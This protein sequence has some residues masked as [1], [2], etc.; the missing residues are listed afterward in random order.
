MT[1]P[2][3]QVGE[4]EDPTLELPQV[5]LNDRV[6]IFG[7]TGTGKSV[8]AHS[9]FR[10]IPDQW[11]RIIIDITDSIHEPSA[12]D[13]YDPTDIPWDKSYS[14]RFIPDIAVSLD[15]QIS[16]LFMGM[17]YHGVCFYWLDEAN[18]ISTAHKTIFGLRKVL[19]QGRKAYV[20]GVSCTPRPRDISK[21][22]ITQ[23]Q[24][25]AIFTIVD[26][27][28]RAYVAKNIGMT[29]AEFD[30]VVSSMEEFEYLFYDV[31]YR[32]LYKVPPIPFEIVD[33]LENPPKSKEE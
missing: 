19:L 3:E 13:F 8:L 11:W 12:L 22:I 29:P 25:I 27:D 26:Y 9:L 4:F 24:Y 17:Y 32:T 6:A 1:Q 2:E 15:D 10:S 14:L 31:R 7:G 30:T 18:E 5:G 21:S 23:A 20:G 33:A 16:E 28:D